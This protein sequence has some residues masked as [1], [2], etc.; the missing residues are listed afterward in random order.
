MIRGRENEER[1]EIGEFDGACAHEL[2]GKRIEI[3]ESL[4]IFIFFF[5]YLYIFLFFNNLELTSSP[6]S[7]N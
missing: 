7:L 3:I 1:E 5:S 4:N 2:L 6:N